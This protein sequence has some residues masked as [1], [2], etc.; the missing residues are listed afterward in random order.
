MSNVRT[1]F[2]AWVSDEAPLDSRLL[3]KLRI[4][5]I[6]AHVA[7]TPGLHVILILDSSNELQTPCFQVGRDTDTGVTDDQYLAISVDSFIDRLV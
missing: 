7:A 5:L 2:E 1:G 3:N 4:A 6:A